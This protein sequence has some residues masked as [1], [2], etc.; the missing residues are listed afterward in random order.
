M[1]MRGLIWFGALVAA[2][3]A[4]AGALSILHL[5]SSRPAPEMVA[6]YD[7]LLPPLG[8]LDAPMEE[9]PA[10][11]PEESPE[12]AEPEPA[13]PVEPVVEPDPQPVPDPIPEPIAESVLLTP[14]VPAPEAPAPPKPRPPV[15]R[16]STSVVSASKA[17]PTGETRKRFGM[18]RG[19]EKGQENFAGVLQAW[20]MKHK[21]YP[22]RA[23]SR[24]MEGVVGVWFRIDRDGN[25]LEARIAQ[26][27]GH[28]VLDEA[29]LE[30]LKRA[31][32]FPQPPEV[33]H[34][35]DLTFTVPIV[36][37]LH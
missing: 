34:E 2:L 16:K 15:P 19:V 27:S 23:R 30:L 29:T 6:E 36:Y 26:S 3:A 25:L 21:R 20:F 28:R 4:H 5:G 22:H 33:L 31:S 13:P 8:S 24:R 11:Q 17:A 9:A 14:E 35:T 18:A 7:V 37:R 12:P 10:E 1:A 32:P